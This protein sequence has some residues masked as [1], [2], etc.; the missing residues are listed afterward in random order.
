L[1]TCPIL[2][3]EVILLAHNFPARATAIGEPPQKKLLRALLLMFVKHWMI[4]LDPQRLVK[5]QPDC[6]LTGF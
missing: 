1:V 5:Q 2:K 4:T 3:A 6:L